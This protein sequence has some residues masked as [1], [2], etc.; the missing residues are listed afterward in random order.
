MH[1][2]SPR[3]SS[4]LKLLAKKLY[5]SMQQISSQLLDGLLELLEAGGEQVA[6]L[7]SCEVVPSRSSTSP[8]VV[9]PTR[10]FGLF[11]HRFAAPRLDHMMVVPK[12]VKNCFTD[13]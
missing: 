7:V 5:T 12:D 3:S 13:F 10:S 2:V 1:A 9:D 6:W 11:I 8:I 4:Q